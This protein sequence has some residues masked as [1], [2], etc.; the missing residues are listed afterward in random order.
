MLS[1]L[2][3]RGLHLLLSRASKPNQPG[4]FSSELRDGWRLFLEE[5]LVYVYLCVSVYDYV[6]VCVCVCLCDC[7][8]VFLEECLV[9]LHFSAR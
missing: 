9:R 2:R 8:S 3:T 5:C 4:N 1:V 6:P 7:V